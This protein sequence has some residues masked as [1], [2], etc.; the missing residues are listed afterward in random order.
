MNMRTVIKAGAAFF[1]VAVMLVLRQ[2]PSAMAQQAQLAASGFSFAVYGDSRSMFYLPYKSDQEAE[3]R[4]LIVHMFELVFPRKIAEAVVKRDVK[5]IYDRETHELAEVIMPF[6]TK[7]EVTTLTLDK[8]WVTKASVEDVKLLPGVHRTMF[9][10][11]GGEWVAHEIAQSVK[12][13]R[14]QLV[15]HTGDLVWWGLQGSTPFDN[16]Y[17]KLVN[18]DV[19]KQLPPPDDRMRAAGLGGRFF[20]A[21]GNHEVW[22]DTDTEGFL[23]TF[24]YLKQIGVSE[25]KLIYK[26]DYDG[27]RFIFLWT[28]KFDEK[29]PTTWG[30][31]RPTYE[32]QM[33]QLAQ[34]LDEA[35]AA[36]IRKVFVSFHNP[37][38]CRS[39]MGPIP[40]AQSPH[41]LLASYAKDLEIVVFNGHVHTTELYRVDGVKYLLLGG[42]GAEQDPILPGRTNLKMPPDYPPN[43]Y[44]KPSPPSEEYSYL[45]VDVEPGQNTKF[46]LNRFRPWSAKPFESVELFGGAK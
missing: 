1:V 17:W 7:Y 27:A 5:F 31:T 36:G 20:T 16:P 39:G 38:F 37:V 8:G 6:D 32:E 23:S 42:G 19:V 18:D 24:P 45:L 25:K 14:A 35:K 21:V 12:S 3:A 43:L 40:E 4:E 30:A 13:G 28:G 46:T 22:E 34:W 44:E 29:K 41:K 9:E 15:L 11:Q 33:K 2:L 26:F 10:L